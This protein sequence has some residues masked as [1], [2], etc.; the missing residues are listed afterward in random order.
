MLYS[1]DLILQSIEQYNK[2]NGNSSEKR[3][4]S[5]WLHFEHHGKSGQVRANILKSYVNNAQPIHISTLISEYLSA[6][7]KP[8]TLNKI[9]KDNSQKDCFKHAK[10]LNGGGSNSSSLRTFIKSAHNS[11]ISGDAQYTKPYHNKLLEGN[12]V[13]PERMIDSGFVV[14]KNDLNKVKDLNSSA[15]TVTMYQH[16]ST[17]DMYF[18]KSLSDG[19]EQK[20][21]ALSE[22]LYS[23]IWQKFIGDRSSK[24]LII[25]DDSN[26]IIG[27]CSKGLNQF[28]ELKTQLGKNGYP[29]KLGLLSIAVLSYLLV[30]DDLHTKNIGTFDYHGESVFGKIDHDYIVSKFDTHQSHFNNDFSLEVLISYLTTQ[31]VNLLKIMLKSLRFSPGTKNSTILNIGHCL[32]GIGGGANTTLGRKATRDF[33]SNYVTIHNRTECEFLKNKIARFN[34]SEMD[35]DYDKIIKFAGNHSIVGIDKINDIYFFIKSRILIVKN[36]LS[37]AKHLM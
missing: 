33:Y 28:S 22:I 16:K 2:S 34:I 31:D 21:N 6:S 5:D 30:E 7:V 37:S 1:K 35:K 9:V 13:P 18:G 32:R 12:S 15:H 17:N 24:S 26:Q 29:S 23:L 19:S 14:F 8:G 10:I 20:I 3:R 27:I 11:I 4:V 36:E 25:M